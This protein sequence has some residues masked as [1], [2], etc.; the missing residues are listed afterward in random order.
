M[1]R[2]Y[3]GH[4]FDM[5]VMENLNHLN[6]PKVPEEWD[7]PLEGGVDEPMV[8]PEVNEEVMDDDDREDDIEWLMA[9]VTPPRATMTV[10]STYEVGGPSTAAIEGPSSPLPAPR[11]P[12]SDAEVA[13]NITIG[14]IHLRVATVEEQ[15]QVME[16][17]T[18]QVVSGLK[19]IESRVQQ[20]ESRVDTY[21]SGQTALH[22]TE[23]QNQ[24]LRTRV[25]EIESHVGILMLYMLWMEE[26]LTVLEKRLPG[27]PPGPHP[28]RI[29]VDSCVRNL[30]SHC[31]I[32]WELG[33]L[34]DKSS[35]LKRSIIEENVLVKL[36]EGK[37]VFTLLRIPVQVSL[38]LLTAWRESHASHYDRVVPKRKYLRYCLERASLERSDERKDWRFQPSGDIRLHPA[39]NKLSSQRLKSNGVEAEEQKD[40]RFQPSGDIRLHPAENKLSSQRL[41][42]NGVEAEFDKEKVAKTVVPV[43]KKK[44]TT[45]KPSPVMVNRDVL[46]RSNAGVKKKEIKTIKKAEAT[47]KTCPAK[48]LIP[49]ATLTDSRSQKASLCRAES[50]KATISK[51]AKK[52]EPLKDQNRMQKSK[53]EQTSFD[54][55][56]TQALQDSEAESEVYIESTKFDFIYSS[57]ELK[58]PLTCNSSLVQIEALDGFRTEPEVRL[59]TME[60]DFNLSSMELVD[61]PVCNESEPFSCNG[62]GE[63]ES[64]ITYIVNERFKPIPDEEL[65]ENSTIMPTVIESS[66]ASSNKE[67]SKE[68]LIAPPVSESRFKDNHGRQSHGKPNGV[69][70]SWCAVPVTRSTWLDHLVKNIKEGKDKQ[71][72]RGK[73]DTPK[74]KADTIYMVQSWQ[75]KTRQKVNQKFSRGNEIS[76]PP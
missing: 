53:P 62:S 45:I 18:V 66:H 30:E 37:N 36:S 40:W 51:S 17:Q 10:S 49:K 60:F 61:P 13:D 38:L 4:Y 11:L 26:R 71:K 50:L 12:V 1:A 48:K 6:D 24:Q 58:D 35:P 41:K 63:E 16:S 56:Q 46:A 15:V 2:V 70:L 31:C 33:H 21:L 34:K 52:V 67:V 76:F 47:S 3:S 14:E 69:L 39:E 28:I 19:E 8:D 74:D 42:S 32:F 5:I 73:K 57:M 75:R 64:L 23:L 72:S 54:K 7:V 20:V 55:V 44:T 25:A 9:S 68:S 22:G 59:K 27:P 29:Y 65:P 43:E